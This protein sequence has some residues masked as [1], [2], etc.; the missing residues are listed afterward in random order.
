MQTELTIINKRGLHARAA[1]KLSELAEQFD[2]KISLSFN[3]QQA[4]AKNILELMML[5]AAKG[6]TLTLECQGDDAEAARDAISALVNN[7]FDEG[8]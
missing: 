7:Y 5:A 8:E 3:D 2:S 4:N 6:S 1:G